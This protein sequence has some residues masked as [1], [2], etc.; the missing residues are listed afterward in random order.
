MLY[1]SSVML[2]Q[3]W[4]SNT[5][6][7]HVRVT[8]LIKWWLG[9]GKFSYTVDKHLLEFMQKTGVKAP[10]HPIQERMHFMKK[11]CG[12]K[13]VNYAIAL[14]CILE[15][16]NDSQEASTL[17]AEKQRGVGC[18]STLWK[19]CSHFSEYGFIAWGKIIGCC[20]SHNCTDF[21]RTWRE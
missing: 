2:C 7:F 3:K 11:E 12:Y 9:L 4:S 14:T 20:L 1:N 17:F 21:A 10:I 15:D 8:T 5:R 6:T 13:A 16:D 18:S 19:P